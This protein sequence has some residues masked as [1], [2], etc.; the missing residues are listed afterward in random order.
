MSETPRAGRPRLVEA[1]FAVVIAGALCA[2]SFGVV[3]P[4]QVGAVVDRN[5]AAAAAHGVTADDLM[6]QLLLA[7]V[8]ALA[9]SVL[10]AA[11]LVFFAFRFRGGRRRGRFAI[12][13]LTVLGLLP[14]IFSPQTLLTVVVLAV[15]CVLM[16]LPPVA[17]WLGEQ[18]ALRA[19]ERARLR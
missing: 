16:F 6:K 9:V 2:L 10:Y 4:F 1:A 12:V 14:A 5:R 15:A 7:A 18:E 17:R 3:L 19:K 8:I 11:A 13:L